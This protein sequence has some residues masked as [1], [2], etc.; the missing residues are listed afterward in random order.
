LQRGCFEQGEALARKPLSRQ[1]AVPDMEDMCDLCEPLS[2]DDETN[3]AAPAPAATV[4]KKAGGGVQTKLSFGAKSKV[5]VKVAEP[6]AEIGVAIERHVRRFPRK[7]EKKE[8]RLEQCVVCILRR[9]DG[10]V[11]L[12]QRPEHGASSPLSAPCA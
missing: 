5:A 12:E 10:R 3:A 8:A 11:M 7:T 4:R 6:S 2:D 1:E 9:E